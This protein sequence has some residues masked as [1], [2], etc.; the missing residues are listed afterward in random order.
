M[1][2]ILSKEYIPCGSFHRGFYLFEPILSG[3]CPI[4]TKPATVNSLCQSANAT[5]SFVSYQYPLFLRNISK[6]EL[7]L[8][9]I[10]YL[11]CT[12]AHFRSTYDVSFQNVWSGGGGGGGH[13]PP[14]SQIGVCMASTA[15][16]GVGGLLFHQLQGGGKSWTNKMLTN[17]HGWESSNKFKC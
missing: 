6:A 5:R 12:N 9:N 7:L 2:D 4:C 1:V 16:V 14:T 11:W 10:Y 13:S 3:I 15:K 8:K 17:V